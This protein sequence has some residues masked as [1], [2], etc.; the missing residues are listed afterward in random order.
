MQREY[1]RHGFFCFS[2]SKNRG[3]WCLKHGEAEIDTVC[4][5]LEVSRRE[6]RT[7]AEG[8]KVVLSGIIADSSAKLPFVSWAE[9]EELV[10]DKIMLIENAYVKK[11]TGL[12]TL[13]IG[14]N[15]KLLD[16]DIDLPSRSELSKPKKRTIAEIIGCEGAFDVI[17]EGDIVFSGE[18][19]ET[20]LDDGTGALL[21]AQQSEKGADIGFG[22]PI[23]ARGNVVESERGYVLIANAVAIKSEKVV[24]A[25]IKNFLCKY[26]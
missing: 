21:L 7:R 19:R 8:V 11:W 9:R 17:V 20:I 2:D 13:Y 16:T 1:K 26:T 12:T 15:T 14:K 4:R 6:I 18:E 10:T 5:I 25:E 22:T 23:K 3:L 24:M